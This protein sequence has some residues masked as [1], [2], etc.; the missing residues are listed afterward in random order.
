MLEWRSAT[1]RLSVDNVTRMNIGLS[2]EVP[3]ETPC[4]MAVTNQDAALRSVFPDASAMKECFEMT[5]ETVYQQMSA[6]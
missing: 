3:V 2:V 6:N 4:V 1:L 5:T